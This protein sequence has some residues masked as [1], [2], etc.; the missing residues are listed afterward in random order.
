LNSARWVHL[1]FGK[2]KVEGGSASFRIIFFCRPSPDVRCLGQVAI[3]IG[4]ETSSRGVLLPL[5]LPYSSFADQRSGETAGKLQAARAE[6]D[7]F[8]AAFLNSAFSPAVAIVFLVAY[9]YRVHWT[10]VP[11]YLVAVPGVMAASFLLSRS[12]RNIQAGII[13]ESARMAGS[14]TEVLRNIEL[15]KSLGLANQ[16]SDRLEENS[17]RILQL[18][19][20][21]NRAIRRLSFFHGAC[22]NVLRLSLILLMLYLVSRR[23]ITIGQFFS[24]FL[25]L[26]MLI[27][28]IQE[29]GGLLRIYRET[30]AALRAVEPLLAEPD[31]AHPP[32]LTALGRFQKLTFDCVS[33]IH[34]GC[35][36]PAVTDV[37]FEIARGETVALVGP[38]GAGKTRFSSCCWAS[39]PPATA[40]FY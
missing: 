29:L 20:R 3:A 22:V 16:E 17:T 39:M 37:T 13:A 33:F 30:E 2:I 7:R 36:Q 21:K 35:D 24:L 27:N 18:E 11:A 31:E 8:L 26:Y 5:G 38:S 32:T 9:A 34:P 23:E 19:L 28:P 1:P 4:P 15:V 12:V 10:L 40:P 6:V 14:A 25:F